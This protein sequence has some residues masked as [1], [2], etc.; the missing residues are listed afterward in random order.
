M[1]FRAAV[2]R[3]SG[4]WRRTRLFS[5]S[6]LT[7]YIVFAITLR[8]GFMRRRRSGLGAT[9]FGRPK[10]RKFETL[11]RCATAKSIV[12]LVKI[13]VCLLEQGIWIWINFLLIFNKFLGQ[14]WSPTQKNPMRF[15]CP[16]VDL[17]LTNLERKRIMSISLLTT[18]VTRRHKFYARCVPRNSFPKKIFVKFQFVHLDMLFP[19]TLICCFPRIP[20]DDWPKNQ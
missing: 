1:F 20:S 5:R 17:S 18:A 9:Y 13:I 15:R 12:V 19:P 7:L 3:R 16:L 14:K 4:T 6:L 11:Q 10:Q 2:C 8:S